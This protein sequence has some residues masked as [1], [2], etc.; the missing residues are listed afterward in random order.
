MS[1][2][3]PTTPVANQELCVARGGIIQARYLLR[4]AKR[5]MEIQAS[6]DGMES[7]YHAIDALTV[8]VEALA[9]VV[10]LQVKR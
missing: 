1:A 9:K 2:T 3:T 6:P 4:Q 7:L 8:S 10:E 5:I